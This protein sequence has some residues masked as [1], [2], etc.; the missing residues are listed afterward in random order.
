M[1]LDEYQRRAVLTDQNP[2]GGAPIP[3]N[4]PDRRIV[5]P[6]LGLTGEAGALL[7]A[8]KKLLRDGASHRRFSDEVSE[9]LGDILW[10]VAD[11][12]AKFDLS[13][14]AIAAQNLAKVGARWSRTGGGVHLY[15][16]ALVAEQQLP[17]LMEYEFGE[18]LVK[19]ELKVV[20]RDR[21]TNSGVGDPLKDNAYDEDGYRFHDVIHMA[22]AAHLG[23]SPV[24]RKL[25]RRKRKISNREPAIVDEVEDGGRAQVVEEA[26]V[27]AAYAYAADHRF[28]EGIEWIDHDLLKHIGRLTAGLEVAPRTSWEWNQALLNGFAAWRQLVAQN[29]GIVRADLRAGSIAVRPA[30][31]KGSARASMP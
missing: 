15:D 13:L 30:D 26:I 19:G 10:Y 9:E 29:G 18:E 7:G 2:V 4:A 6:L 1:E 23:W 24:L 3:P 17:R 31:D 20:I 28:L 11:V 22:L 25:L 16:E 5:I 27:A 14:E 12:A 8:Y 21:T